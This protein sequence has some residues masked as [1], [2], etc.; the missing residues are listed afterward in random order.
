MVGFLYVLY[1]DSVFNA[2]HRQA[3]NKPKFLFFFL[4]SGTKSGSLA[5]LG[6][7]LTNVWLLSHKMQHSSNPE[8]KNLILLHHTFNCSFLYAYFCSLL[9]VRCKIME[10]RS[11]A[12]SQTPALNVEHRQRR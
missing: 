3:Q 2:A 9:S 6:F 1:C 4:A 7:K 11:N 8:L 5:G 10:I 12:S